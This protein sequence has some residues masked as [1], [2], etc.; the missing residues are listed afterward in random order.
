M[1]S[2][3]DRTAHLFE[4]IPSQEYV[5]EWTETLMQESSSEEVKSTLSVLVFNLGV[6]LLAIRTIYIKEVA[7]R[8]NVHRIPHRSGEILQGLVNLNGELQLCIALH[9]LL[10][11]ETSLAPV[12]KKDPRHQERMI[13]IAKEGD[14]WVFHVD[15]IEGIFNWNVAEIENVPVTVTKSTANYIRGIMK[16]GGKIV[17]LIDDELL[18]PSLKRSL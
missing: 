4:R 18:F 15:G 9:R 8:R 7:R 11:I 12:V 10:G 6:E 2:S 16:M 1:N 17:G 5:K 14:L 3:K 13:A